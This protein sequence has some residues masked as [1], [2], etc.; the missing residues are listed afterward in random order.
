MNFDA[1]ELLSGGSAADLADCY[2]FVS[3]GGRSREPIA[4]A[5]SL[6]RDAARLG[7]SNEGG[8]P[9]AEVV[10]EL[11]TMGHGPDSRVYTIGYTASLQAFGLLAASLD[12]AA[13][14]YDWACLPDLVASV[15]DDLSPRALH[16]AEALHDVSSIDVAGTGG[17]RS[18]VAESALLIRESTRIP[19][20]GYDTYQYLHG[21][22]ESLGDRSACVLFGDGR[23]VALAEYLADAGVRTVLVTS[24]PVGE[25]ERL[26]TMRLPAALGAARP[27]IQILPVQLI[28]AELARLRGLHIDGFR[29]HQDD[30][31]IDAPSQA[32]IANLYLSPT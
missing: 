15:L 21:P 28:A 3:E 26:L 8:V 12:R 9:L 25:R 29:Y 17:S 18:A 19:A 10:D 24:Q 6:R 13:E 4:A 11:I 20:S 1:G 5:Q 16:I 31:K 32:N 14:P 2:I 22:M 7:V 30:T 27:I 23:E